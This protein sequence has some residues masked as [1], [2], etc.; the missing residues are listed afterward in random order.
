MMENAEE[1]TGPDAEL[2]LL[3]QALGRDYADKLPAKFAQMFAALQ[4]VRD[5]LDNALK[6]KEAVSELFH[7]LHSLSGSAGSFG[8]NTLGAQARQLEHK[9]TATMAADVWSESALTELRVGL[10][11]LEAHLPVM[12]IANPQQQD[13]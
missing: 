11:E 5:N 6:R 7:L 9:M 2:A 10:S 8:F 13:A 4:N 3:I 1:N 12:T